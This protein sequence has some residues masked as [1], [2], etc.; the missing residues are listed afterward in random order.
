M[1]VLVVADGTRGDVQPMRVLA[2]ALRDEGHAV[3][4]AAPPGM[5]TVIEQQG[6]RFAPLAM[7]SEAAIG[8]L[9]SVIVAGPL[10]VLRAAPRFL[11][12]SLQSQMRALP[13]LVK[14]ADFI[15][16]GGLHL[17]IPSLA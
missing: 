1:R 10:A 13:Q 3:T 16:P 6:L 2:S 4:M 12:A 7:D 17:A 8:E 14:D 5:R 9:A 11:V 15:L